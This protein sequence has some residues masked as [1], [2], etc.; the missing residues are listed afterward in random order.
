MKLLKKAIPIIFYIALGVFLVWYIQ[1]T[2]FSALASA[3][4]N[5]WFIV[6]AVVFG[7]AF[8]YWNAYIW[9]TL[10]KGLGANDVRY[11]KDLLSVYAKS[12]LGRY[13]PGKAPWILGKIYFASKHGISK[14]K[15]AISSLLEVG[16]QVVIQMVLSILLLVFDARLAD[17]FPELRPVII[18]GAL[19]GIIVLVPPIFNRLI[20][21]F[22]QLIRKKGQSKDHQVNTVTILKAAVLYVVASIL[23]GVMLYFIAAAV[24]PAINP[25][26]LIYIIG[27]ATLALTLG[28]VALF[29]PGGIGVR[30]GVQL[31]LLSI[32][33]PAEYAL[34]VTVITRLI[35][36]GSDLIFFAV[37]YVAN[38]R[39][40]R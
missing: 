14:H 33:M 2:D 11:S 20:A 8:C 19:A 23:N 16:V 3:T 37:S 22:Y 9:I 31:V 25:G 1:S 17:L 38:K 36:V 7:L 27:A 30:D 5:W 21:L 28:I 13:I 18:L 26:D 34:I 15:L 6:I 35:S 12:W 24:Y 10:L 32:I 29:A 39:S 4:I 40:K